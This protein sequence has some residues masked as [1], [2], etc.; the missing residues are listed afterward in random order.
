[1]TVCVC[2][3]VVCACVCMCVWGGYPMSVESCKCNISSY[4]SKCRTY[5]EHNSFLQH[6]HCF[7]SH[8]SLT[9]GSNLLIACHTCRWN[10]SWIWGSLSVHKTHLCWTSSPKFLGK[11]GWSS[12][13]APISAVVLSSKT[14]PVRWSLPREH[15]NIFKAE[16]IVLNNLQEKGSF[17]LGGQLQ[18]DLLSPQIFQVCFMT[19]PL[20]LTCQHC[21]MPVLLSHLKSACV[22]GRSGAVVYQ[23]HILC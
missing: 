18:R 22:T 13:G 11:W 6:P 21:G 23:P 9:E 8:S 12:S 10:T 4:L 2:V 7:R 14:V 17:P 1:M 15:S 19:W 16:I 20:P 5:L 3:C